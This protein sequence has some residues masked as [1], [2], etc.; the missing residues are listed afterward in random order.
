MNVD[1]T[2]RLKKIFKH[3]SEVRGAEE[4]NIIII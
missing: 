3:K 2:K 4:K 1:R